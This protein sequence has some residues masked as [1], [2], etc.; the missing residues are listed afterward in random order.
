M[1]EYLFY[2]GTVFGV[3][4]LRRSSRLFAV[5]GAAP[6]YHTSL[7]SPLLFCLASAIIVVR[8]A[9]AH[10]MQMVVIVLFFGCGTTVYKL[11]WW[12]KFVG[13]VDP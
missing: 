4:I 13:K 3:L 7:I 12:Q 1:T 2:F 8:S 5:V 11:S 6:A 9:I 10:V